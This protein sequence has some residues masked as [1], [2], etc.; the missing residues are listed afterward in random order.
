MPTIRR[1]T[2]PVVSGTLGIVAGGA[3]AL[4]HL[5]AAAPTG[6]RSLGQGDLVHIIAGRAVQA[7]PVR[8]E[9][10]TRAGARVTIGTVAVVIPVHH[11][12][13]A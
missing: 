1:G 12:E 4:E 9:V 3:A 11:L 7:E 8:I 10:L 13:A 2:V 6:Q 5:R